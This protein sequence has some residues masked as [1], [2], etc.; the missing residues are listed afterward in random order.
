[1]ST[2]YQ[3]KDQEAL[4]FLT[5]QV[6]DWVDIFT[7]KIYKDIMI[8]SFKYSIENKGFQLFA[9][10]IMSNH[11]HLIANSSEGR[12]S[13]TIRDL[14][15][16]TSKRIT[17]TISDIHE[18]RKKWILNRFR[19]NASRHKNNHSYQVWTHENHAVLLYSNKFIRQKIEYI[20]NNPVKAGI[21]EKAEDY[22]YSSARNYASLEA[23]IDIPVLTLPWHTYS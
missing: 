4:H 20:H 1:M 11:V 15:K 16:F 3:I 12:L 18:S 19:F 21:V 5:F 10:V 7:R 2:G 23:P 14:K 17:E 22:L 8:E 13:D 6:V 9:Y